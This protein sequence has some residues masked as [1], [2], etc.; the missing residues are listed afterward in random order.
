M[1]AVKPQEW[2]NS[3]TSHFVPPVPTVAPPEEAGTGT[4]GTPPL[5]GGPSCPT[6]PGSVAG[7]GLSRDQIEFLRFASARPKPFAWRWLKADGS[8]SLGPRT[9]SYLAA[10]K[11]IGGDEVKARV[12]VAEYEALRPYW[13]SVLTELNEAGRAAIGGDA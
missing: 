10:R 9:H 13:A 1:G 8:I 7:P 3:A 12:T 6:R 11:R 4:S 2:D 5:K